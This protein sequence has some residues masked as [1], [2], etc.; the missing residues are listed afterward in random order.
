M[1]QSVERELLQQRVTCSAYVLAAR[2]D[3]VL[4]QLEL[5]R[6]KAGSAKSKRVF[7][8]K[9]GPYIPQSAIIL[10]I[11]TPKSGTPDFRHERPTGPA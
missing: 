7:L 2:R 8:Q 5:S 4:Q 1:R 11:R 9:S 10:V 6:E 3:L